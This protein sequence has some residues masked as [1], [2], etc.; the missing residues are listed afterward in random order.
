MKPVVPNGHD[1]Y[2]DEDED[3]IPLVFKRNSNTAATTN[4]PSPINNAMRNSAIG[5]TKS[6]PPMRSPL[7]S[8]NRSASSSTRSSM[9]KPALPSSSSVQRSTLKSPLRDDRSVVAKER[10][11]F[12][13]APSVS[14][15]DDEDSEDDKPLSARLKLDSKEVTKQP[16]SSGRGSTQQAV[17]KSN[18]RPQGLSDYTKKKVLDERAPMSSTV[19]TKTSVGTSSSKPVHIEQK[20]PL[21]NNIDRNGLKPKTEGHSSQAPAKR[22]LEKGS[23]SNQSSVKRPKLSEPARPVKVEQGSHISATQDAKGKNLDA[24]KPLRANQATVKEDNSDGD[25]HV[26]IASRMK[27][28]SSNNKSSSAKPSSS[29]MIASS[30]RTIAQKPNKWVKDSKY[31]KSS[32]SLPSGDGQKKWKTLQHNGVIFPPPYKRHGVKI[33]FQGKPVDLTPEQEEVATMFAVM[34]ETEYYKKPKFR[35]NFWNDWRKLLGKNH[36]IKSLDDCDFTPIYEWYMQEKETKKQMT[37]E[38]NNSF[39]KIKSMSTLFS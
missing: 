7:T 34:R 14:K 25:D 27:S 23:S 22:P 3:D 30:S 19:Q 36:M 12:G 24:S 28:D 16:S 39:Y 32:K 31:S 6:S 9:M 38:V 13:K 20:R 37:A 15:S 17:Q 11:G 10:N 29:K 26:P 4:R 1:G 21:V 18:M 5:S 8:P 2:E 35:E 33:L